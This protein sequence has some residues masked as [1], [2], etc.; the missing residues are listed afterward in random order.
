MD[1]A[2]SEKKKFVSIDGLLDV[3]LATCFS[4][5]IPD[6]EKNGKLDEG[7]LGFICWSRK[8]EKIS[9]DS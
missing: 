4:N 8:Q 7:M 3:A 6:G 1:R 9:A 5:L 2:D